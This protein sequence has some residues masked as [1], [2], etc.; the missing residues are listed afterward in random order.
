MRDWVDQVCC[1]RSTWRS[2]PSHPN[3]LLC[4]WGLYLAGAMLLVPLLNTWLTKRKED[5][6][7]ML[8]MPGFQVSLFYWQS[9]RHLP[10]QAFS[11][12]IYAHNLIFQAAFCSKRNYLGGCFLLKGNLTEYCVTFT[13]CLNN[14]YLAPVSIIPVK[15]AKKFHKTI[16]KEIK[17]NIN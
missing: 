3:L 12:L 9:C 2:W 7:S 4:R 10:M 5:G 6:A 13:I 11:L 16:L 1:L 15:N 17:R 14:F 8:N